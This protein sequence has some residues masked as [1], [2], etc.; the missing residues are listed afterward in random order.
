MLKLSEV[1][2]QAVGIIRVNPEKAL[3]RFVYYHFKNPS[4][5]TICQNFGGQA[6]QPNINLTVLKGMKLKLPDIFIQDK[7]VRILSSYDELIKNNR[8]R[9]QLLE[10][11]ARLLYREWFVFLRF[12]GHEHVKVVDGVP[13]GW[14]KTTANEVMD[15]L[16]GGTP[17]TGIPDY[18]DGDIPF[19]TPKDVTDCAFTNNTEKTITELG[20]SKCNS[21]LYPKYTLFITARGT[22]GKLSFAQRPMAMNQSCYALVGKKNISQQFLYCSLKASIE[23]F[24]A[25]AS[26]SVFD[27]IVVDTFKQIPFLKPTNALISDFTNEVK[28]TFEQVD[29]LSI[30]NFKLA[31]ARDLLLPRLMNGEIAV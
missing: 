15:I 30:M 16:S 31:E 25:R 27:A 2:N 21:R 4:T 8:R 3:P 24:K 17:K 28:A 12:P 20:L 1:L 19:F 7:I 5:F 23:Q 26:G 22:V 13:E 14:E 10:E 29:K 9:I 18:W 11:S 6:A